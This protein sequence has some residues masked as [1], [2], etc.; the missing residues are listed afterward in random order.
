MPKHA[1]TLARE[2]AGLSQEDLGKRVGLSRQ[3]INTIERGKGEPRLQHAM[4]IARVLNSSVEDLFDNT[5]QNDSGV[6]DT[7]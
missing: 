3:A 1:L 4:R 2:Q 6:K 5:N 7:G